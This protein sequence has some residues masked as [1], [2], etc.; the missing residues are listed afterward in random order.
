MLPDYVKYYA[1]VVWISVVPVM[2]PVL[3]CPVNFDIPEPFK[4]TDFHMSIKKVGTVSLVWI[5][6]MVYGYRFTRNGFDTV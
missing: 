3:V 2:N 5:A 1:I 6:D 4:V